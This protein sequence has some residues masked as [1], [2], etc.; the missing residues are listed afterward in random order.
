MLGIHILSQELKS[1]QELPRHL[2]K[3]ECQTCTD[4]PP[5][6]PEDGLVLD[7]LQR[8]GRFK[9]GMKGA[10]TTQRSPFFDSS[11]WERAQ[12]ERKKKPNINSW[13]LRVAIEV[14]DCSYESNFILETVSIF[15]N[16]YI[17]LYS[18]LQNYWHP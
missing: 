7:P 14:H 13:T 11:F 4:P 2:C 12:Q 8:F 17:L 6:P 16:N 15:Y 18:Q 5:P 3:S 10:R 1:W 9:T